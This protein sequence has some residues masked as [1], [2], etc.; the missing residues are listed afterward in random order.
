MKH[1]NSISRIRPVALALNTYTKQTDMTWF[2][3]AITSVVAMFTAA[4]DLVTQLGR[5][6]KGDSTS[7]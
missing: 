4:E 5:I 6:H 2:R 7:A 3:S 1:V